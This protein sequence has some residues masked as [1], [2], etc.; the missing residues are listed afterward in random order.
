MKK[1]FPTG[2]VMAIAMLFI[3][4]YSSKSSAQTTIIYD[5]FESGYGNWN[6]GGDDCTRTNS[7]SSPYNPLYSI[8]LDNNDGQ[9]SSMTTND[10]DISLFEQVDLTF[11]F[12]T[13]AIN[14]NEDFWVRYSNNGGS[15]WTTVKRFIRNSGTDTASVK[16]FDN[17]L[18]YTETISIDSGSYTFSTNSQFRIQCDAGD[19][20]DD[21]Y[22]NEVTVTGHPPAQREIIVTS[23]SSSINDGDITTS[24][25][26]NTNFGSY[27]VN[28]GSKLKT[29]TIT[30]IGETDLTIGAISI[31]GDTGEFTIDT[32]PSDL[33]LSYNESTTFVLSFDPTSSTSFDAIVSIINNDSDENPFDFVITGEGAQIYPD[34]DGDGI[35]D[36]LDYDDD[37][38]G[39]LDSYEQTV[40]LASSGSNTVETNF[41]TET[42]ESGTLRIEINGTHEGVTST[43]I[44]E[45]G[46]GALNDGDYTVH[47]MITTGVNGEPVG[48]SDAIANWAWYAWAPIEDH[49]SGDTNGRMAIFNADNDPG[50][51]YE[52]QITGI[53]PGV[54]TTYSFW[55]I[56]IDNDDS[57][58][59]SGELDNTGH[60]ILPNITVNF[61]TTDLSTVISTFDTGDITRCDGDI[62]IEADHTDTDVTNHPDY[63]VYNQCLTSVWKEFTS[64]FTSTD[65]EFV[66]QFVN[67]KEG[68]FGNDLAIDDITISQTLCDLDSDGVGDILDLDNDDDGIPNIIEARFMVN[69]DPDGDATTEN[70]SGVIVDINNNG[71]HDS[72]EGFTPI[73]SDGDLIDDYLDLD[74]DNDGIFDAVEYETFGD[75]D[76]DG[77]GNG[78]GIDTDSGIP[79]DD[80]DGDGLLGNS[81]GN[82]TDADDDDHGSGSL[83]YPTPVDSDGDGAPDYIDVFN[84]ITGVY[85]IDRT[86]YSELIANTNGIIDGT[87]DIDSDG[88]LDAF[89]TDNTLYGSPRDLDASYSLFFDGRNDYVDDT[90]SFN[91]LSEA[92]MMCWI[93]VD[94]NFEGRGI[95]LGQE[96]FELEMQYYSYNQLAILAKINNSVS[97]N[98]TPNS[99]SIID[100]TFVKDMWIHVGLVYDGGDTSLK[101]YINGVEKASSTSVSG[102]TIVS[103]PFNF[104]I[105]T[106][107]DIYGR[108]AL[109]PEGRKPYFHGEIDEVR[110]FDKALTKDEL[111]KMVHQ[112]LDE[113]NSFNRG[114]I[115]SL[116]IS[117]G[118]GSNLKRYFKMDG[119]KNDILDDK[120]TPAIDIL[121]GAKIYNVKDIK[122][123][124][125][126]VPYITIQDGDWTDVD[127]W[128]FGDVWDITLKDEYNVGDDYGCAIVQVR[129]SL[130]TSSSRSSL[131]LIVDS[132]AKFHIQKGSDLG[133]G[134]FNNWYLK[135]DGTLDLEDESQLIQTSKSIFDETS[136]G[137]LE[138]DQ[139]GTANSYAYNYWSSPVHTS[140]DI[141][142][143]QSYKITDILFDGTDASLPIALDFDPA[144][145]LSAADPYYADGAESTPRKIATYWFWKFVNS[146]NDYA[147]WN[148]VGGNN[149][150]K[151]SEGYTMKGVSG[152]N[153]I[154][155]D[156]NYVFIGKPNNAPED[157][158]GE[159]VHTEFIT[160]TTPEGWTYNSLT[161]NPFPSALDADQFIND[162]NLSTTGTIYFWEHWGGGNHNWADYQAGYSTYTIAT[163]VPAVAHTDGSGLGAGTKAP[164]RYIPVGQAFYIISSEDGGEVVFNNSQRVFKTELDDDSNPDH[165]IFTREI[166]NEKE[167]EKTKELTS[168]D[169]EETE[170]EKQVIR[171][172][173]DS[174]MNYH[175]QIAVAFLEGATDSI[176]PGYDGLAGDFLTNDAFFIQED[177]Y[178]VIQAFGEF[179]EEREIPI[180]IFI[181][182]NN[183]GG[184]ERMMVDGLMNVP[185]TTNIY[186]KDNTTGET[187]DIK[188]GVY[189]VYLDT[190]EHKDRFSLVFKSQILSVEESGILEDYMTIFMN[191]VQK[192]IDIAK[193]SEIE[194]KTAILYNYLGQEIQVWNKNLNI[195][196]IALPLNEVSSGAYILKLTADN[197]TISKKLIIQ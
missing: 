163:G 179:D 18:D 47:H 20:N 149:T 38:D 182:E 144:T 152:A 116:D 90:F 56:N 34:T 177:K 30:N 141:D 113:L 102:S 112:E 133:Q 73:D 140:I 77:D 189:E 122:F 162:N 8:N 60:R 79:N 193:T 103:S 65:S 129:D 25:L 110:V 188:N 32:L 134:L 55:A 127:T 70:A 146:G 190:G 99:G 118:I 4:F 22:I 69:P 82:D 196:Q 93:K 35:S 181:D 45:G 186:I 168:R 2:I 61:L 178:F 161:G 67:N 71:V 130:V 114:K 5:D 159:I 66:V 29:Y 92:T 75:I 31:T 86:I 53:M 51:F 139:Q 1:K 50:I 111:Q 36:N 131:G 117:P 164:G 135:L 87:S 15:T 104:T 197:K 91:G 123:Q 180:S 37:N 172:G 175:R 166:K 120:T 40:C 105:G 63:G 27:D 85:D 100:P 169:G 84:D 62:F 43:Y 88:I 150:L 121:T 58:F 125:A 160:T 59:N 98:Y 176:D 194:I 81:D 155:S 64:T 12:H 24:T 154:T 153:A 137:Q 3:L 167:T 28:S 46:P 119:Y 132:G 126:P 33:L 76:I 41:L 54:P 143:D 49:T 9:N 78:D 151:A 13:I 23:G 191:N 147:N 174:P 21:V 158:G 68:G 94:P 101:L 52:Y 142:G 128:E 42:F 185:E 83:G 138:R 6:D 115:V 106:D 97:L 39:L 74:S 57:V 157:E 14:T 156:Q 26:N 95:F 7:S 195:N 10:L 109:S 184:L 107:A 89:D 165:S 173:F 72:Y 145:T 171:L 148:W 124:T 17:G 170:N 19:D 136:V 16:Y 80:Q 96:I 11:D 187:H 192:T 48:E 44:H 183:N 108:E